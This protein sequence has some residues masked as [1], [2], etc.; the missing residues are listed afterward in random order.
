MNE[1]VRFK[2]TRISENCFSLLKNTAINKGMTVASYVEKSLE[3]F[4]KK[5]EIHEKYF[6]G[7]QRI[8][9]KDKNKRVKIRI[10][11]KDI[12]IKLKEVCELYG[13]KESVFIRTAIEFSLFK[14]QYLTANITKEEWQFANK[15]AKKLNINLDRFIEKACKNFLEENNIEYLI[16]TTLKADDIP[17]NMIEVSV[18]FMDEELK[19]KSIETSEIY[20]IPLSDFIR[21]CINYMT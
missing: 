7:F 2:D 15:Q 17:E 9:M 11:S 8:V 6:L 14:Y 10:K 5:E 3:E 12:R 13:I 20:E 18:N 4:L 19:R 1:E 16:D 21:V